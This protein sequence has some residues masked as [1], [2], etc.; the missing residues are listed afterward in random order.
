MRAVETGWEVRQVASDE[1]RYDPQP[2]Q[3]YRLSVERV[4]RRLDWRA[5]LN[6][7]V[8][9]YSCGKFG[10]PRSGSSLPRGWSML[11]Q[12]HGAGPVGLQTCSDRCKSV[13]REAMKKGPVTEPLA[14]A[15]NVTMTTEMREQMMA[16]AMAFVFRQEGVLDEAFVDA[17]A[18]PVQEEPEPD[19][20]S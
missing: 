11:Y 12:P 9:C 7:L 17:M 20:A 19:G 2:A 16:E 6:R 8:F 14:M 15:T 5:F 13:V 3:L 4:E 18:R 10:L 1:R